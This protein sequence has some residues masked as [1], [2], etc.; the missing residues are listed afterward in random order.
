MKLYVSHWMPG[1]CA[2]AALSVVTKFYSVSLAIR[3]LTASNIETAL[4]TQ[5]W[6]HRNGICRPRVNKLHFLAEDGVSGFNTGFS[7]LALLVPWATHLS[8]QGCPVHYG[9]LNSIAGL[10][11][12]IT[13]LLSLRRLT[14]V[15]ERGLFSLI[16]D[17][18]S[19][20]TKLVQGKSE[21]LTNGVWKILVR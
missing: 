13:L 5:M 17:H 19:S 18:W 9:L 16:R 4:V 14:N 15:P 21:Q 3:Y 7:T 10:N 6:S 8:L 2:S 1:L 20:Y 12:C 11:V